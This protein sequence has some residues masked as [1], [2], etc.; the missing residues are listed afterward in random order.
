M[1]W[2]AAYGSNG[3]V[4]QPQVI[5]FFLHLEKKLFMAIFLFFR[6]VL[7]VAKMHCASIIGYCEIGLTTKLF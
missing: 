6:V 5:A 2:I 1:G 7:L 4:F 3:H